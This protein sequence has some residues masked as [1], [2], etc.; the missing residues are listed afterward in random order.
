M[1]IL[2]VDAGTG[3]QDILLFDSSAPPE[4]SLKL[5]MPSATE[6]AARRIR[7]ATREG[8]AVLL[9]GV[10][11]G[12]GPCHWALDDHLKAGLPA[13]AT[14]D[15]ARTFDDDLDVVQSMG[16]V[17][18]SEDE[19]KRFDD[20]R[21]IEMIDL[22]VTAIRRALAAFEVDSDFDGLALACLDH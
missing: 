6:I 10:T 13:Y 19:A 3:T 18:V 1:R 21:H 4:S 11:M 5:I 9:T 7:A 14:P 16:V 12:G 22:D 8:R 17:V 15:A 20:A 2:A